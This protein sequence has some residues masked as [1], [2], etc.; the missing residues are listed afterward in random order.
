M[1]TRIWSQVHVTASLAV[2]VVPF[3][4]SGLFMTSI[5][6]KNGVAFY[7]LTNCKGGLSTSA[8]GMLSTKAPYASCKPG[9]PQVQIIIIVIIIIPTTQHYCSS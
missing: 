1:L 4:F 5:I 6:L 2:G 3:C 9:E 7:A 8:W